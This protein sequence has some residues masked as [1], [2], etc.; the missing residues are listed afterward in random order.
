MIWIELEAI[1]VFGPALDD[2]FVW[3]EGAARHATFHGRDNAGTQVIIE[4]FRRGCWPLTGSHR[5]SYSPSPANP[6]I[7]AKVNTL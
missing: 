4:R 5:E 2:E 1:R 6:P 7:P 3:R